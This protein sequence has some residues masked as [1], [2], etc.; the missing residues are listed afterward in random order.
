MEKNNV[1]VGFTFSNKE[2]QVETVDLYCPCWAADHSEPIVPHFPILGVLRFP[3]CR[4]TELS[5][6]LSGGSDDEKL[7]RTGNST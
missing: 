7:G 1:I 6:K 3:L 4:N 5:G 2:E